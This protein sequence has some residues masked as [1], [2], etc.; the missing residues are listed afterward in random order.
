MID[1]TLMK[2]TLFFFLSLFVACGPLRAESFP[3]LQFRT[4]SMSDGLASNDV[5]QIYQDKDGFVWIATS[6][7]VCRYDGY[8]VQTLKSNL[9]TPGLLNNNDTYC[10]AEDDCHR[11]WIGTY[12]GLNVLDKQTGQIRTAGESQ[13]AGKLIFC[14]LSLSPDTLLLGMETGL[15]AYHISGDSCEL[16]LPGRIP[17]GSVKSLIRDSHDNLWVGTW[18]S[19]FFRYD[20]ARDD[21]Q[22]CPALDGSSAA[23]AIFEDSR[24]HIWVGTWNRGLYRIENP[25][26][27]PEKW[28]ILAYRYDRNRS[29]SLR[30]DYVYSISEDL[31]T[32][33]IWVATRN[34]LSILQ[35]EEGGTFRNYVPDGSSGTVSYNVVTSLMRDNEGILWI[36]MQGGGVNT[37]I[38]HSSAFMLD[39]LDQVKHEY[40]YSH[41]IRTLLV[42]RN[43]LLWIGFDTYGFIVYDRRTGRYTYNLDSKDFSGLG[44]LPAIN[45]IYQSPATSRIWIGTYDWGVILYDPSLPE[46]KRGRLLDRTNA[47]WLCHQ[48]IL[49]IREDRKGNT[50]FGTRGG[51]CVLKA[52][53]EAGFRL[54]TCRVGK[55]FVADYSFTA[56]AEDSAGILWTGTANGGI[57]RISG[58]PGRSSDLRF[59]EYAPSNGK[60]NTTNVL[61]LFIDSRQRIW[62]GTEGGGLNLFDPLQDGFE[63]VHQRMQLPG[64]AI[65]SIQEDRQ[66]NLWMAT[67]AGLVRLTVGASP[68]SATYRLYTVA[69]G[70]LNS[71]YS[72]NAAFTDINGEMFFAGQNGFNSFFP[73]RM[74]DEES[75]PPIVLTDI[76]I[77]NR[78][79][80]AFSHREQAEISPLAPAFSEHCTLNYL[81]NN[82]NIE[83]AALSY[84]NPLQI[85]YAYKLEGFDKEWRYTDAS[86][87]FAYYNNLKPGNYTFQVAATNSNGIWNPQKRTLQVLILPPPWLSWWAYLLYFLL[88]A[89][90]IYALVRFSRHRMKLQ[91]ALHLA[92]LEQAKIQEMNH[93]KLQF[94]TNI[95]H[96]LLTPLTILSAAVEELRLSV[97]AGREQY[98][99]MT[100][101]INRLIR[102]LQQILEFRKAE[103]GNLKLKVSRGDLAAFVETSV[104]SFR[105]LIKKKRMTFVVRC[106]PERFDA[107]FDSDKVD[108]IVY[109]LLSNA[110][111]YN[112]PGTTVEITLTAQAGALDG[113]H[114]VLQ[115]KDNGKGLTTEEQRNL[116]K[117]FY[118]GNYRRFNTIGTGIG[119]SLT[120]D[121]VLLHHGHIEVESEL[122]KGTVFRVSLPCHRVAYTEEEIDD[123]VAQILVSGA[124]E[125]SPAKETAAP[126]DQSD[127]AVRPV[128]S[129]GEF[130]GEASENGLEKGSKPVT[131]LHTLL[132]IEDNEELLALLVRLLSTDYTIVTAQTGKEGW[133]RMEEEEIDL[134]VSDIMM[135]EMDG[136]E[137]CR[138]VKGNLQTSHI[139]L[140]LLTAKSREQ[141][142]VE[143]Y[144]A[145][146]DGFISKPFNLSVLH[147]KINNLLKAKE[148]GMHDFK[149]QLV[150]QAQELNYTSVDED[151]LQRTIDLIHAHLSDPDLD[152]QTF[153]DELGLSKSTFYRKIK[154][155][156]GL[157]LSTFIRNIRLK[158]ACRLMEE[159]RNVRISEV[160]YAVGFND[161]KY[162][163][164]CFKKEFGVQPSEYQEPFAL[165]VDS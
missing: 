145:G 4:L 156:T 22:A 163:S 121:L 17:R 130:A 52:G 112:T 42:D 138:Q 116:F 18:S 63:P 61:C 62:V 8:S 16:F 119:L 90:V 75:F 161:P 78:S 77:H 45:T 84:G 122:G 66:G 47:P 141:D 33:T 71:P 40:I 147:A 139:P 11:L 143:A 110:A 134:V 73:D 137:F 32:R 128:P 57:V 87:R 88:T 144:E 38:T 69:D 9:Y 91:N 114:A 123:T 154:S 142:R 7:G 59:A 80:S 133:M 101:N 98:Q 102:L 82:F 158:A 95:T 105:P 65:Y 46:G 14:M 35:D 115:V 19:G 54:D 150:F 92:E 41:L 164:S 36:G 155:L 15:Y 153:L 30:S 118:E 104:D 129:D 81:R 34:G 160:A 108:K 76:K 68:D 39:R 10:L 157:S 126:T 120:R 13:L 86:R 5:N 48:R 124:E 6:R 49:S 107:Y 60:L 151:F 132:L 85:K 53:S 50:W 140:I 12:D 94:F 51:I 113:P 103:T 131:P 83:F 74:I 106:E 1:S 159:K 136:I 37:V 31:N 93:L 2:N 97:P 3:S 135:P 20:P 26:D 99:V 79:W 64:D 72:Q 67:Q 96:E 165:S 100:S 55:R 27:D 25:Y 152:Q 29:N 58:N 24:R 56:I 117:R 44:R 127:V 28:E 148:R 162:F 146:A 125:K 23:L 109:N 111:K 89:G 21:V 43:G 70:L 149:K